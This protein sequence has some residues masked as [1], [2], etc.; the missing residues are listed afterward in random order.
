MASP[1]ADDK[2]ALPTLRSWREA[3]PNDRLAHLIKDAVRGMSRGLQIRLMD[4][5]V[6][7]GH[8][9]FL[10]ILWEHDGITQRE[11]SE[12]AGVREPTTYS[13]LQAME[14]LGYITRRKLPNNLRNIC[15][16]LTPKGKALKK[17]LVPLAEEVNEVA[18]RGVPAKNV[19]ILR[20][21]LLAMI[22]NLEQDEL[23]SNRR[24]PPSRKMM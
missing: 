19:A 13:A 4:H 2:P 6:S 14:K 5:S 18:V 12:R 3:V 9:A 10:R 1:K 15:I 20:E 24:V 22:L 7:L 16:Y 21:T 23:E 17:V 8:W 11:L